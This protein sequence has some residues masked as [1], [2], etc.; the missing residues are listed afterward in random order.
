MIPRKERERVEREGERERVGDG[1]REKKRRRGTEKT[2]ER[3]I[4]LSMS[5]VHI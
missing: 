5:N 1:E 3:K 2:I 4:F